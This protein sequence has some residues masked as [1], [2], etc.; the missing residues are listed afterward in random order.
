M[1]D[2]YAPAHTYGP[3]IRRN[4]HHGYRRHHILRRHHKPRTYDNPAGT[5]NPARTTNPAGTTNP[6]RTTN[7]AGTKNPRISQTPRAPHR[8]G[9]SGSG[10][11]IA[12][13]A[14][15]AMVPEECTVAPPTT[16]RTAEIDGM[17]LTGTVK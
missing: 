13:L 1:P 17:S 4:A 7:P 3:S 9:Y 8:A 15:S 5:T 2:R 6:A 16:V 14:G 11:C 12:L 10:G